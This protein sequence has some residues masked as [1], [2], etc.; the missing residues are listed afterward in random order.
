MMK[1]LPISAKQTKLILAAQSA[2]DQAQ[3][4]VNVALGA[5]LAGHDVEGQV[6]S[7]DGE[8]NLLNIEVP[9]EATPAENAT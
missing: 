3:R 7:V 4:D 2:L 6:V 1:A 5:V 9:D 8:K